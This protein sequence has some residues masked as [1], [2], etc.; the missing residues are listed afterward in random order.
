MISAFLLFD[1]GILEKND[2]DYT[3]LA[4]GTMGAYDFIRSKITTSWS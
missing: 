2:D 4:S 1:Q 3:A